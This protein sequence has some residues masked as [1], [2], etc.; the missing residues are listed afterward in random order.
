MASIEAKLPP[1]QVRDDEKGEDEKSFFR[2][3]LP[4]FAASICGSQMTMDK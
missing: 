1:V 4:F 3:L 2:F